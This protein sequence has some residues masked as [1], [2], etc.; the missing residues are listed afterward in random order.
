MIT[1]VATLSDINVV[2][3]MTGFSY[4]GG[5]VGGMLG[6]VGQVSIEDVTV[7]GQLVAQGHSLEVVGVGGLVG[8][9][10]DLI[11]DDN[12]TFALTSTYEY[13]KT[14]DKVVSSSKVYY[15]LGNGRYDVVTNAVAADLGDY[16][17]RVYKTNKFDVTID[18]TIYT[19]GESV[20]ICIGAV[21]GENKAHG[22]S[23][24]SNT[25]SKLVADIHTFDMSEI[26]QSSKGTMTVIERE[27]GSTKE[28]VVD[29][30]GEITPS[31]IGSLNCRFYCKVEFDCPNSNGSDF[32]HSLSVLN[33]GSADIRL[34]SG[35]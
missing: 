13:V 12:S 3:N 31:S 7:S 21:V 8:Q 2:A 29:I 17:E 23:Y 25:D 19:Y 24:V 18:S 34:S 35:V 27:V 20:S 33:V 11:S 26:L 4:V 14:T 22:S 10:G 28:S 9:V 15:T 6:V 5:V 16:F 30:V 1:N 32:A